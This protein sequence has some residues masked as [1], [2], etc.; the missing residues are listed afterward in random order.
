MKKQATAAVLLIAA[1]LA[2]VGRAAEL[3]E[4]KTLTLDG[5]Q[6]AIAAAVAQ[7]HRNKA[8]GV[9]AVVDDGGN[10]MALERVDRPF[11]AG[12]NISFLAHYFDG[13]SDTPA[14]KALKT[15]LGKPIDLFNPD[16]FTGRRRV[17][18]RAVPAK[19]AS[20]RSAEFV[21]SAHYG[22]RTSPS[23]ATMVPGRAIAASAAT[24]S[25]KSSS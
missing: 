16:G 21:F 24:W 7:A 25:M 1:N 14:S 10:L 20:P 23:W 8:G 5:A 6:R 17:E 18:G 4:H 12:A 11:A 9:I 22:R 2:G 19:S 3:M 15:T 13:A